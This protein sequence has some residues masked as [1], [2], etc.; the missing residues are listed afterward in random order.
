[1][2]LCSVETVILAEFNPYTFEND[3]ALIKIKCKFQ[4]V[5]VIELATVMPISNIDCLIYGYGSLKYETNSE[6]SSVLYFGAVE[7]ISYKSCEKLLGRAVAP[8]PETGQ[9]CARGRKPKYTD[10][11]NGTTTITLKFIAFDIHIHF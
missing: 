11:C 7:P 8:S 3:I 10:A 9:F 1:M 6:S 2:N 4:Q 5:I